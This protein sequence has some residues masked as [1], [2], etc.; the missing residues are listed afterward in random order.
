MRLSVGTQIVQR[1]GR[2]LPR[3]FL[4]TQ[5]R[6]VGFRPLL[7][8]PLVLQLRALEGQIFRSYLQVESGLVARRTLHGEHRFM[9]RRHTR[10]GVSIAVL[11]A[12]VHSM[13]VE[14]GDL[15]GQ[16]MHFAVRYQHRISRGRQG[17]GDTRRVDC[18]IERCGQNSTVDIIRQLQGDGE[19]VVESRVTNCHIHREIR[20][21][22]GRS[23]GDIDYRLVHYCRRLVDLHYEA[24]A[25]L[26]SLADY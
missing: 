2:G 1:T 25:V 11:A 26:D 3:S 24:L 15:S 5:A 17:E 21:T 12:L 8:I 20:Q 23:L 10:R 6:Q 16:R 22:A 19:L 14:T 13:T 9:D 7:A 4:V 18:R